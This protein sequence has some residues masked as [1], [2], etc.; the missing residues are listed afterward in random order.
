MQRWFDKNLAVPV[1]VAGL[2]VLGLFSGCAGGKGGAEADALSTTAKQVTVE[3]DRI[4]LEEQNLSGITLV[5][6]FKVTNNGGAPVTVKSINYKYTFDNKVI[7]DGTEPA[8]LSVPSGGEGEFFVKRKIEFPNEGEELI[9]FLDQRAAKFALEGTVET[10]VANY[11]V[12]LGD[13]IDLPQLPRV[14][15]D[16]ASISKVGDNIF[17]LSWDIVLDNEDNVFGPYVNYVAFKLTVLGKEVADKKEP[18]EESLPINMSKAYSYSV[19]LNAENLGADLI[20]Q[21]HNIKEMDYEFTGEMR[22]KGLSIPLHIK[23][24]FN[25][26][27]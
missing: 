1:A 14:K 10:S 27:R 26:A 24:K 9:K 3:Y 11:P 6:F 23:G 15:V 22:L 16:S 17:N 19:M 18:L 13:S 8:T 7:F 25:F 2:M 12:T 21:L 4:Q 20:G 5:Y